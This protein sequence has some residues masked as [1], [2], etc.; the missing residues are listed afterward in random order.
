MDSIDQS[1]REDAHLLVDF[2]PITS[3][4]GC[5]HSNILAISNSNR[6][7]FTVLELFSILEWICQQISEQEKCR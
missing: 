3:T 4:Y 5:I 6:I 7:Q 1:E 2:Y